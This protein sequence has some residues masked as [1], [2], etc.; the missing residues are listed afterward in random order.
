MKKAGK[1]S[2]KQRH[3]A[4]A[5]TAT[6]LPWQ[7]VTRSRCL[8]KPSPS[9]LAEASPAV[10]AVTS[11]FDMP[12]GNGLRSAK[13]RSERKNRQIAHGDAKQ[14]VIKV[15][16]TPKAIRSWVNSQHGTA[17]P[18]L[19]PLTVKAVGQSSV[20]STSGSDVDQEWPL[21][22]AAV[23]SAKRQ[24]PA[25][26]SRLSSAQASAGPEVPAPLETAEA[27]NANGDSSSHVA[28]HPAV[29][30]GSSA[31]EPVLTSSSSAAS[32]PAEGVCVGHKDL[33]TPSGP[34]ASGASSV[35]AGMN[36][37]PSGT[38]SGVSAATVELQPSSPSAFLGQPASQAALPGSIF[39]SSPSY[40]SPAPS[41][42][43]EAV[44]PH[45]LSA[46]DRDASVPTSARVAVF[47]S[48]PDLRGVHTSLFLQQF[49]IHCDPVVWKY[50]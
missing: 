11:N 26:I 3:A 28:T 1:L 46:S 31:E 10:S 5:A 36:V 35:S 23:S 29:A 40:H 47:G 17:A 16:S 27:A 4:K 9:P 12:G 49:R 45:A 21:P 19:Q 6:E 42:T 18:A 2:K 15:A 43:F 32:V 44:D 39:A 30:A 50:M 41:F 34:A 24:A 48:L 33:P 8:P 38:P 20:Y 22:G 13:P 25:Q 14:P 37:V 7:T